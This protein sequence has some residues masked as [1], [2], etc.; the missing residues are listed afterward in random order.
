MST[1]NR[2]TKGFTLVELLV[3][4]SIIGMLMAL[5]LPAV[6][7]ARESGRSNT[8]RNNMRNLGLAIVQY[9]QARDRFPGYRNDL[10]PTLTGNLNNERSWV[11]VLLPYMDHRSVYDQF[12][13]PAAPVDNAT[14]SLTLDVTTCPSNPP[15]TVGAGP[16]SFVVNSGQLDGQ[17]V[18][19]ANKRPADFPGNGVFH[20]LRNVAAHRASGIPQTE[21]RSSYV[22][23]YDGLGTTIM[24]LENADAR[25]WVDTEERFA[26]CTYSEDINPATAVNSTIPMGINTLFGNS[27]A[28]AVQDTSLSYARP[29][30]FHPAGIN[31]MFCDSHVRFISDTISYQVFQALMSPRGVNA[32]KASDGNALP[33]GHGA[34]SIV[35]EASIR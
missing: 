20:D 34:P 9:E 16:T 11:F 1:R 15:E 31:V 22:A 26:G 12:A 6:Q 35:D 30:S 4:I 29:S 24:L 25:S 23:G 3:V 10:A 17:A 28:G 19:G 32:V 13:A 21:S 14:I 18:G 2:R 27:K 5:L 33:T 7:S 8:C